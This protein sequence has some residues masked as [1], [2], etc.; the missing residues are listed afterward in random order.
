MTRYLTPIHQVNMVKGENINYLAIAYFKST[1][2]SKNETTDFN[3]IAKGYLMPFWLFKMIIFVILPI[4]TLL[5][6]PIWSN[7]H[8]NIWVEEG[9]GGRSTV[10]LNLPGYQ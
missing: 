10:A 5:F 7:S 9:G 2:L 6:K 3:I 4:A 1:F 8:V